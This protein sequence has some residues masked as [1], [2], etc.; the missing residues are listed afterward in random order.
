MKAQR[1]QI[2]LI[3]IVLLLLTG[4][5]GPQSAP[6][7]L[8]PIPTLHPATPPPETMPKPMPTMVAFEALSLPIVRGKFFSGS[9]AC[10]VCHANL[11]DESGADVSI[12]T[13]WRS[14]MMANAARDP[15]WQASVRGEMLDHPEYQAVI[16]DKCATCH[17]PM[18]RFT[19]AASGG[20]GELFDAG[21]LNAAHEHHDLA[22]DG[23]SCTLCHQ[24]E[25]TGFGDVASFSGGFAIDADLRIGARI[26]FGPFAVDQTQA[27]LMQTVSG[28]R[29]VESAHIE[30]SELCATCHTLYT[31]YVDAEGQI[32]GEF[33][34][35][36]VYLE[37]S[38]SDYEGDR[39]CQDCHM[40][41]AQGAV[42]LST[43]GSPPHSPFAK[44][45]FVG[46]NAYMLNI[47]RAF[48]P[49]RE[50][51]ASSEHFEATIER[52]MEQLEE[53]TATVE[54]EDV[55]LSEAQLRAVVYIRSMVGHKFPTGFP[56]RRVWLHMTVRD[57]GGEIVFESGAAGPDGSI[58]GNDNDADPAEYEPH[59][60]TIDSPDQVQVYETIVQN[61]EG[62]VT[63]GLLRAAA[64]A[65]DNR[66]L[67][68]GF[69]KSGASDDIA[70]Y[71]EAVQDEDFLG[72]GDKVAYRVELNDAQGPFVVV[73]E[74][75]YQSVGYRWAQ[76]L[77]RHDASET[78][79]FLDY[80]E[81]V[82]N[83]P[84]LVAS[85]TVEIGND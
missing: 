18:V 4:C 68:A 11:V 13:F 60:Q 66:L 31:P 56:A 58:G 53:R 74:L 43:T 10:A 64:C 50:L 2:R 27:D 83:L 54:I 71:G 80:Y 19:V 9:G 59:Y 62:Q 46:G 67:P 34:E 20:Q 69:S 12:D 55:E 84:V 65:K 85:T 23:V 8:T 77:G 37:W 47:L 3:F 63:T 5:A 26:N 42:E 32:A 57:A 25:E 72:G 75:L 52:V 16:E 35:Q 39:A 51:T 44:H 36:T 78:I 21:F 76:N 49:E 6:G 24:I 40:P 29:P 70:V 22:I 81:A 7:G 48:G 15:Y 41:A 61:T 30:R 1:T 45:F 79:R 38:N 73:V 14:T 28:F 17:T 33:P 82:P